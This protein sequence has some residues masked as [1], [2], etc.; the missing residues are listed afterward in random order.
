[1]QK[2][3][4]MKEEEEEEEE[5]E[6]EEDKPEQSNDFAEDSTKADLDAENYYYIST[7]TLL[8][9]IFGIMS[10]LIFLAY[11]VILPF[12]SFIL[13]NWD[14]ILR[15]FDIYLLFICTIA[16]PYILIWLS[17]IIKIIGHFWESYSLLKVRIFFRT[18]RINFSLFG[19][20]AIL[21]TQIWKIPFLDYYTIIFSSVFVLLSQFFLDYPAMKKLE[22]NKYTR[23][24][25]LTKKVIG[26]LTHFQCIAF[27]GIGV[28]I[29]FYLGSDSFKETVDSF[30]F[31]I[32]ADLPLFIIFILVLIFDVFWFVISFIINGLVAFWESYHEKVK[33]YGSLL[34]FIGII[35]VF[36]KLFIFNLPEFLPD[37]YPTLA[38]MGISLG[39][40]LLQRK[41]K[42]ILD[43]FKK[44][45]T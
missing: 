37:P 28:L 34:I 41:S 27:I 3:D 17:I 7:K 25:T 9:F 5:E 1:M 2:E 12:Q 22:E 30:I 24:K 44:S 43:Y 45:R 16:I 15:S 4:L 14:F 32:Y 39:S 33:L 42:N 36:A 40:V 19:V 26:D 11:M 8:L 38:S 13:K 18:L 29:I 21:I 31:N 23:E 20:F 6:G 10:G 35:Y